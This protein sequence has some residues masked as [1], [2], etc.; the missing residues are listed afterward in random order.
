MGGVTRSKVKALQKEVPGR[1]G[2]MD[3]QVERGTNDTGLRNDP[4]T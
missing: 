2:E 1:V 4:Q 3:P